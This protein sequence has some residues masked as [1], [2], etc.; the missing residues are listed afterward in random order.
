M[1]NAEIKIYRPDLGVDGTIPELL[2][3]SYRYD[4]DYTNEA[5]A[6]I[7][8]QA[9]SLG[10]DPSVPKLII[11]QRKNGKPGRI[12]YEQ[13]KLDKKVY[14]KIDFEETMD[15][16]EVTVREEPGDVVLIAVTGNDDEGN[17]TAA[18]TVSLNEFMSGE[19]NYLEQLIGSVLFYSKVYEE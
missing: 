1:T 11:S 17:F 19:D 6:Y 13:L 7:A 16:G 12:P 15:Y 4:K 2:D 5:L 8:E 14:E 9:K 18:S 10:F 3:W